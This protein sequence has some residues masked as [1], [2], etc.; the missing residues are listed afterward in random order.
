MFCSQTLSSASKLDAQLY[1]ILT[2]QSNNPNELKIFLSGKLQNVLNDIGKAQE[3]I[4]HHIRTTAA[5]RAK[6]ESTAIKISQV[7]RNLNDIVAKLTSIRREYT[8]LAD[9]ILS[10]LGSII[11]TTHVIDEYFGQIQHP[12]GQNV[13]R[14]VKENNAFRD[15]ILEQFRDLLRQSEQLIERVRVQEPEV[16]R[17][18]DTDRII[19]L[20]EHLRLVFESKNNVRIIELQKEHNIHRFRDD[21]GSILKSIDEL[22]DQLIDT[23]SRFK[24]TPTSVKTSSTGFEYFENTIQVFSINIMKNIFFLNFFLLKMCC[25]VH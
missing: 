5:L 17:E 9:A 10:F 11:S 15:N 18:H 24:E 20:L 13:E 8:T 16:A 3:E 23:Q 21:L 19:G 2:A 14:L 6:D 4:S 7:L 22:K 12:N 25:C 1:P